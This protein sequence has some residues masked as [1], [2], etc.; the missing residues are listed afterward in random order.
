M[1]LLQQSFEEHYSLLS[2]VEAVSSEGNLVQ[3]IGFVI[4]VV[5]QIGNVKLIY[6]AANWQNYID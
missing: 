4:H 5:L 2:I 6:C 1:N 3:I